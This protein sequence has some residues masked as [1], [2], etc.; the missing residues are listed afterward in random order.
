MLGYPFFLFRHAEGDQ[1][2]ARPPAADIFDDTL[3]FVS[4]KESRMSPDDVQ[5]PQLLLHIGRSLF[6]NARGTAKEVDSRLACGCF[7]EQTARQIDT[8]HAFFKFLALLFCSP[9]DAGPI[10]NYQVGVLEDM[11][12]FAVR[13][14]PH[15]HFCI[16]R[17]NG[18]GPAFVDALKGQVPGFFHGDVPYGDGQDI[19]CTNQRIPPPCLVYAVVRSF[20]RDVDIVR[21]AFTKTGCGDLDELRIFNHFF[22]VVA[23]TVAH[24]CAETA[25][26]L[27]NRVSCRS[28]V[29][30]TAFDAF[31]DELLG[32][33]LEVTVL[34]ATFHSGQGAHA[35]VFFVAAALIDDRFARAFFRAGKEIAHHDDVAAGSD[36]FGHI[37][38]ILDAAVGDD[39]DAIALSDFSTFIDGRDLRY[40][41]TG[42]DTGRADGARADA[43]F[44]G[45]D[46]AFDEGFRSGTRSDVAGDD[47]EMRYIFLISFSVLRTPR[48]WP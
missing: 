28:F 34:T 15:D 10:G 21:M 39:G 8:C 14:G 36:G 41:D 20:F 5:G 38:G 33:F 25:D 7:L 27:V 32:I 30:Y 47:R 29:R 6:G 13:L 1:E 48:E 9:Q 18:S 12:Q 11:G 44:D 23:A 19:D 24:G 22:N 26:H 2:D 31:G 16:G 35:A 4:R 43:D 46:A 3:F 42:D 17:R 40:A 37:T 45:V